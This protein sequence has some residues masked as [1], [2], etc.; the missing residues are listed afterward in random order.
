LLQWDTGDVELFEMNPWKHP[1]AFKKRLCF[2]SEI[3]LLPGDICANDLIEFY[4]YLY[5]NWDSDLKDRL[6]REYDIRVMKPIRTLS[7]G[8]RRQ[9][10]LMCA[11]A[12]RPDVL[13]LDEP[14]GGL[15]P[16]TRREFLQTILEQVANRNTTVL[17]S[18]HHFSDIERLAD[19]IGILHRGKLLVDTTL[20]DLKENT[21]RIQFSRGLSD[22]EHRLLRAHTR[23][24]RLTQTRLGSIATLRLST[25]KALAALP[26]E[27]RTI[28]HET[29][30]LSLVDLF[31]DWTKEI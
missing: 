13:V 31:V 26:E 3:D 17:F 16:A 5:P 2:V 21:C 30:N 1:E 27:L 11:V 25:E 24:I 12:A 15:D 29:E 9:I 8:H 19:R 10:S 28:I 22:A 6:I 7:K 20:D 18:S 23:V 14:A 4:A